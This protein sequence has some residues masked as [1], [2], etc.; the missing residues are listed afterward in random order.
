MHSSS[1]RSEESVLVKIRISVHNL[2]IE[3]CRYADIPRHDMICTLCN[4]R[5]IENEQHFLLECTSYKLHCELETLGANVSIPLC[6]RT[7]NI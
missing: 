4:I 7:E 3:K 1:C 2:T 6:L 5:S